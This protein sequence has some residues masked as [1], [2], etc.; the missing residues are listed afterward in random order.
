MRNHMTHLLERGAEFL[1]NEEIIKRMSPEM[2]AAVNNN[3][4]EV[5]FKEYFIRKKISV[6]TGIFD[7]LKDTDDLQAAINN[8]DKGLI[9]K[10][11]AFALLAVAIGYGF[12][13]TS[14]D[15]KPGE[16]RYSSAEYID[17]IPTP[18]V[19]SMFTVKFGKK[20]LMPSMRTQNIF[21]NAYAEYRSNSNEENM[22]VL[23]SPKL[24]TDNKKIGLEVEYPETTGTFSSG[25]AHYVE[26]RLIGVSLEDRAA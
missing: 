21:A 12:K 15:N 19:N 13:D 10:G 24:L 20:E 23:P 17:T 3:D 2:Q 7:I 8:M 16:V 1:K 14:T 11:T 25:D 5:V 6:E 26:V 22:V 18:L 4:K 9:Q